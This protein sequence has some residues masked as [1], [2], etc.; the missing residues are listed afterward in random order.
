MSETGLLDR[1][2][3]TESLPTRLRMV[4]ALG[5]VVLQLDA[6]RAPHS[7]AAFLYE[8]EAGAY[9]GGAFFRLVRLDN[10][11]GSPR[12]AVVQGSCLAERFV[13]ADFPHE[14]TDLTELRHEHGT[15]S[16]PRADDGPVTA[17]SF[18]IC[19]GDQPALD[20]GG[21]RTN[22]GLGFA[23]FGHVVEG[24][25]VV[26]AIHRGETLEE[27][28]VDYLRGQ[29]AVDPVAIY[30]I[31]SESLAPSE[32]LARLAEDY[33]R[34]RVREFPT[35]ATAAGV[36]GHNHRLE[37]AA[38]ADYARRALL[39]RAL[40]NRA[41]A[42]DATALATEDA[43]TLA[44]LRGQLAMLVEAHG[45][46]EHRRPRMFPFSFTD[47]PDQ[48]A[49][50]TALGTIVDRED[51]AARLEAVPD[52]FDQ[53]LTVLRDG[54]SAGYRIPGIL[55]PRLL[56]MLDSHL[57]GGLVA[58][59]ERRLA[60]PIAATPP[61]RSAEQHARIMAIVTE[62][63]LPAMRMVRDTIAALD[64]DALTDKI[65]LCDQPGGEAYYR[66][67]VRQQT[68]LDT[69]PAAIHEIGVKEVA[70][71]HAE[72]DVLLV[73]MGRPGERDAVA[74]E[75]DTRVAPDGEALLTQV[76]ACA[77]RIDGLL[78]PLFGH[79]PGITYAVEP[80]EASA[81]AAMPPAFAQPS[82]ADR[83]MPGIFWLTA[84]PE[85]CPLHL[86]VPLTLHEAWPGHLMQFAL[87]YELAD[88]PAF[89]RYGWTD[90]NGYI[91]GWALYCERLGHD[92]GLYDD[93]ANR[94][95]LL[96]F[97]LWR[98]ARLVVDTGI[99][100]FG[101]SRDSAIAY[102][103]ANTFL[104][105]A[106]I[107]SEVDRYIGMPAQA[108]S[109]KLGERTIAALR[110]KAETRLGECFSLRGFHDAL[111]STGPVSLTA[112]G[113]HMDRWIEESLA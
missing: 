35:E 106:T 28:P 85:K 82:P 6:E 103:T 63:V 75:L 55:V 39:A 112:L 30:H 54:L 71:I 111:L 62:R 91:E 93:P 49:Q 41:E 26:E 45:L 98:A 83:S 78:P 77:K 92:M 7:T 94:F 3:V 12:I 100:R 57:S 102:M 24:M 51:F 36:P 40:L 22:D 72:L 107:E 29:M 109:Y 8:V 17:S 15:L 11:H 32:R 2:G 101:W 95:G 67:K 19:V 99:H 20:A 88:L 16:L 52:F 65:G 43:T 27:A 104:P 10:D 44:L 96:T 1:T 108:L 89:R 18:F 46:D 87:A 4:T 9:D 74:A 105:R 113:A 86:V 47:L 70:R 59:I 38:D 69:D 5:D 34:F 61:E 13:T 50:I 58:R 110:K 97:E 66:F 60:A 21:G 56:A 53:S 25:D 76:R 14:P 68:S 73:E 48:M 81:S 33:W 80:M 31:A 84:L 23:A 42:I 37:G 64:A 79:M 90:Y